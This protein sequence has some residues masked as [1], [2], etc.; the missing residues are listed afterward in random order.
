MSTIKKKGLI[1]HEFSGGRPGLSAFMIKSYHNRHPFLNNDY[2]ETFLGVDRA[3]VFLDGEFN[4]V[5][6]YLPLKTVL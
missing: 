6:Y 1:P 2:L 3:M 5:A 4:P